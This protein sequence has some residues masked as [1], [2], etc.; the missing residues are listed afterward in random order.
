M[1]RMAEFRQTEFQIRSSGLHE[2]FPEFENSRP[3][4]RNPDPGTANAELRPPYHLL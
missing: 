2:D 4:A 1:P 3:E